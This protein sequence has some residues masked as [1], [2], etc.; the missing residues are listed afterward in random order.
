[1]KNH[2]PLRRL[3][4]SFTL[5]AASI[6]A[7]LTAHAAPIT[8]QNHSF[9]SP[10]TSDYVNINPVLPGW[11]APQWVNT[12][13][14]K[15]GGLVS[16]TSGVSGDQALFLEPWADGGN[17]YVYQNTGEVFAAGT[18]TVTVDIGYGLGFGTAGGNATANFQLLSYDG[19]SYNYSVGAAATTVS[20]ATLA[21]HN[22]NLQTYT[23]T[24]NLNGTESFIGDDVVIFLQAQTTTPGNSQ[25]VS[26]DNVRLDFVELPPAPPVIST[27]PGNQSVLEGC[28]AT[29]SVTATGADLTYQWKKDDVDIDGAV[30]STYTIPSAQSSDAGSYTVVVSNNDGD[31]TSSAATLTVNAPGLPLPLAHS[32]FENPVTANYTIVGAGL[33]GWNIDGP[34]T[35]VVKSGQLTTINGVTGDQSLFLEPWADGSSKV[36]QNTGAILSTGTYN[37]LVDV[38]QSNGFAIATG[39]GDAAIKLFAFDGTSYTPLATTT[40][41]SSTMWGHFGDYRTYSV[42]L[43]AAGNEPWIGQTLVIELGATGTVNGASQNVSMD[44]VRL[45]GPQPSSPPLAS[46]FNQA[47]TG[48]SSAP[49]GA[50]WVNDDGS[51]DPTWG[52]Q[53]VNLAQSGI[54]NRTSS[55]IEGV[56]D[57]RKGFASSVPLNSYITGGTGAGAKYRATL[58][59]DYTEGQ[60]VGLAIGTSTD[61]WNLLGK[62][63]ILSNV[64]IFRP[65]AQYV[66]T[67]SPLSPGASRTLAVEVDN[68]GSRTIIRYF[69]DDAQVAAYTATGILTFT[70]AAIVSWD[71][72]GATPGTLSADINSFEITSANTGT[73]SAYESWATVRAGGQA[74]DL[75]YDNDGVANGVEFFM[76]A[77]TGFTANP[78]LV[79]NTV[80]WANGGNIPSSDYG[81]KFVVQ[82]STDLVNWSDVPASGDANLVN[83]SGSVAYTL[84]GPGKKFARLK[85]TP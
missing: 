76:N 69:Q 64:A 80:T 71:N 65:D 42:S 82:T 21:G 63:S 70:R 31:V 58:N 50:P 57:T 5:A 23:F 28:V 15:N 56:V 73:G 20:A 44:N 40:V 84:T 13:V 27:Q 12:Y 2:K 29:L 25:N 33:T 1:M 75:D 55:Y 85:V 43:N 19:S 81:S 67:G 4:R 68:T 8:V 37:L 62:A 30:D 66:V 6:A 32:S 47:F 79:G 78:G 74:A 16:F 39:N 22:G 7:G 45:Y 10:V 18:Y 14:V 35:Y 41:S 72:T 24:L 49:M 52:A 60:W 34:N 9:E 26:Y 77:A 11:S 83:T 51:L 61:L 3:R 48:T 54:I 17:S 46:V 59:L 53:R 38:G 36:W